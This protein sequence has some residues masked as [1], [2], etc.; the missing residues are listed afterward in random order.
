[1]CVCIC[2]SVCLYLSGC[3]FVFCLY[4]CLFVCLHVCVPL[5][6]DEDI[7][8]SCMCGVRPITRQRSHASRKTLGVF[9]TELDDH[10]ENETMLRLWKENW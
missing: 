9:T 10:M 5:C 8:L 7:M 1:M 2:L 6:E 3:V 4:V